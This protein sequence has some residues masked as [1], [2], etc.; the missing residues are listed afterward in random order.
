MREEEIIKELSTINENDI[1]ED[2]N[3]LLNIS[4]NN[5]NLNNSKIGSNIV[6]FFTLKERLN[7]IGNHHINFFQF[8]D[9]L[10]EYENKKYI[11]K[12]VK[13]YKTTPEKRNT[14]EIK[15]WYRIFSLYFGSINI[16]KP[17]TAIN[18]YNK[19]ECSKILDPTMGWGGRLV[20]ACVLNKKEY[21]GIDSNKNLREPYK[22]MVNFLSKYSK[23]KI[24]LFFCDSLN[25]DYSLLDYD[26]VFTSPPY[27]NKEIY[28]SMKIYKTKEEWEQNFYYPL[29][30]KTYFSLKR[31]GF[32]CLNIPIE[33]YEKVCI[34]ILGK[35]HYKY[36]LE[37][38]KRNITAKN[39]RYK[40]YI[41]CWHKL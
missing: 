13:Y 35:Y 7:T 17:L 4:N 32:F 6:N 39:K 25:I 41:Y 26:M 5:K 36:P 31:G 30:N 8:L 24:K 19:F 22:Q 34:P 23:T 33:I 10:P 27:Y 11:Q 2:Y 14:S 29:F 18:I 37:F 1:I 28:T 20:G 9:R 21:I 12:M 40:E 16:F 15:M 3:K 38:S